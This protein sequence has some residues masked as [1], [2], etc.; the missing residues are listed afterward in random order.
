[1][2]V[3]QRQRLDFKVEA[4]NPA[5]EVIADTTWEARDP[6]NQFGRGLK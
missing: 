1:V 2:A 5:G 6:V 3:D 4:L